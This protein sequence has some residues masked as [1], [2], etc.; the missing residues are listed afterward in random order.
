MDSVNYQT[1]SKAVL[2]MQRNDSRK[3]NREKKEKA[4]MI[5]GSNLKNASRSRIKIE[6]D[7]QEE[8]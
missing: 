3:G 8:N 6:V 5:F 1:T 4:S 2:V 7:F